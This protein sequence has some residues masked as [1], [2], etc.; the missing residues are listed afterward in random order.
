MTAALALVCVAAWTKT[1]GATELTVSARSVA[2]AYQLRWL[3][4]GAPDEVVQRRRFSQTL[5]LHAWDLLAPTRLPGQVPR[6]SDAPFPLRLE[7]LMRIDHDF[8]SYAQDEVVFRVGE[9]RGSAPVRDLVPE[10]DEQRFALDLL[11]AYVEGEDAGGWLDFRIGRQLDLDT[12]S[13]WAYDGAWVRAD[14]PWRFAVEAHG[15][16]TNRGQIEE[17]AASSRFEP[18][19]TASA[20]CRIFDD[21]LGRWEP[22]RDCPQRQQLMPTFGVALVADELGPV[23][24]R[25][26]YRQALSPAADR[27]Y[28]TDAGWD[29]NHESMSA[30]AW[31]SAGAAAA[32]AAGRMNL[33]L[34]S[35]DD[36]TTGGRWRVGA[37]TASVDYVYSLP[38]FDGDSLWNVFVGEGYHE[39][40]AGYVLAP[41]G[42]AYA[43]H[44]RGHARRFVASDGATAAG[45]GAGVRMRRDDWQWRVDSSFEDGYGG[46]RAGLDASARLRLSPR[47]EA[48][49]RATTIFHRDSRLAAFDDDHHGVMA[50][51]QMGARWI[52]GE[53]VAMHLIAEE[54]ISYLRGSQWRVIAIWDLVF[55]PEL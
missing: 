40:R 25:L 39:G 31:L 23:R 21:T 32:W 4:F 27:A 38:S 15:G 26:G 14:T 1:A 37:H 55:A 10:L 49:G 42:S 2:Q 6:S 5:G 50:G 12:F 22:S 47:W 36:A 41:R 51:A 52:M 17:A 35:V 33:L 53:G 29:V 8:G 46:T 11:T 19:G 24:A 7:V 13:W 45:G 34:G 16:L 9:G 3:R 44:A 43:F 28:P 48:S 54:N 20:G 18:S 30:E